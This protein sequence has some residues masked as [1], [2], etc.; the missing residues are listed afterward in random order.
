MNIA[1]FILWP[2][3]WVHEQP[4]HALLVAIALFVHYA[5]LRLVV[6]QKGIMFTDILNVLAISL[7]VA[8]WPYETSM[9]EWEKTVHVP[10][11]IDLAL[12]IGLLYGATVP[13][14]AMSWSLLYKQYKQPQQP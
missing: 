12:V 9:L 4:W 11:R 6:W 14:I 8:F 3:N 1:S 7:W 2:I 5:L 10:I 13:S